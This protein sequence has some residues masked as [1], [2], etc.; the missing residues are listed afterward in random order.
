MIITSLLIGALAEWASLATD[1]GRAVSDCGNGRKSSSQ[2]RYTP[3]SQRVDLSH[4]L[5]YLTCG[6][7]GIIAIARGRSGRF[8]PPASAG[9]VLVKRRSRHARRRLGDRLRYR[10]EG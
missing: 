1:F 7:V 8:C 6:P 2:A 4:S 3:K 5:A 10:P 9:M